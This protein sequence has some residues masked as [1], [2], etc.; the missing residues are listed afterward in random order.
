MP[1]GFELAAF[2]VSGDHLLLCAIPASMS[3]FHNLHNET[4]SLHWFSQNRW[5]VRTEGS[6]KQKRA[7]VVRVYGWFHLTLQYNRC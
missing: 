2:R 3:M 1:V 6:S 5:V 4:Y 7:K